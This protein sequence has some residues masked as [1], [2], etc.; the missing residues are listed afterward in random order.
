MAITTN[1]TTQQTKDINSAVA[2]STVCDKSKD[3]GDIE[4]ITLFCQYVNYICET[5]GPEEEMIEW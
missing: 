1:I 5:A 3:K 4:Q 2:Y